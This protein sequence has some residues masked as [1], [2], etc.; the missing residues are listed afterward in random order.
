MFAMTG[1][2]RLAA[3]KSSRST[4]QPARRAMAIR[5]MMALVE[6]PRAM[7]TLIAFLK[8]AADNIFAGPRSSQTIST[9]RRPHSADMR[10]WLASAAGIDEAPGRVMPIA[11]A[12]AVMVAA[13]PI[14]MQV[15]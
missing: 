6:Q 12:I 7:A 2:F 8:E 5:W 4:G 1:T 15:P 9:A 10:I 11:S 14:V 13:V 3:S